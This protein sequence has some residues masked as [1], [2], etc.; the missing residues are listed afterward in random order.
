MKLASRQLSRLA[1]LLIGSA[2]NDIRVVSGVWVAI[3]DFVEPWVS[4]GTRRMLYRV[5]GVMARRFCVAQC[6]DL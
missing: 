3:N 2:W 1:L 5:D 4:W 6:F